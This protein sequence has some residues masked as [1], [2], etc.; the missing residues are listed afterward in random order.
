MPVALAIA[1]TDRSISAHRMTKVRPTAITP[2]TEICVRMLAALSTVA[3]EELAKLKKIN[4]AISVR[5]GATLRI[6]LRR[7]AGIISPLP[8]RGFEQL[9]LADRFVGELAHDPALLHHHD[10]VGQRQHGFRLRRHDDDGQPL[11]PQAA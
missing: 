7:N 4:N 3:K 10:A 5:K 11:I 1:A 8:S 6:W 9:V 2:A